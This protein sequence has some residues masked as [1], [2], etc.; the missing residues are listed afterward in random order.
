MYL[1]VNYYTYLEIYL[2]NLDMHLNLNEFEKY[3]KKPHQTIK[4][5]LN[6]LVKQN[7]LIEEKKDRFLFYTINKNNPLTFEY[8]SICEKQ[9]LFSLLEK[10]IFKRLYTTL[11]KHF[12]NN[13]VLLFGSSVSKE[14]F[15]DIDILIISTD[16][17][18]IKTLKSFEQTY[19]IKL[20][21]LQT[22]EK[23]LT[24]TFK[25]ELIK[26]HTILNEYDYFINILYKQRL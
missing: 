13:K 9:K 17:K 15:N 19:S 4:R 14:N 1:M 12:K 2:K 26:N 8:I 5:H 23:N 21:I 10:P 6:H 20:H 22:D 11:S 24:E 16:K 7:I 18:I 3:F 25:K